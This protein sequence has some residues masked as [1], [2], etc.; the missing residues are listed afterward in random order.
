MRIAVIGSRNVQI[1]N[2]ALY[3]PEETSEIIT[4]GAKGADTCAEHYAKEKKIPCTV[5][6]PDYSRYGRAA[7]L[8]RNLE[9]IAHSDMVLAFL[10]GHSRGTAYVI[11]QC[12][13]ANKPL[14]VYLSAGENRWEWQRS[15]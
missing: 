7:P 13:K 11:R 4:G 6:L 9:I 2:L 8:R 10:D 5:F 12:E 3:L 14:R 15:K 1:E